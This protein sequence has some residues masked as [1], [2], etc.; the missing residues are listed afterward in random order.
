[1]R[2]HKS[3]CSGPEL[4]RIKRGRGFSYLDE[5]GDAV[6]DAETLLR[7]RE[8][9]SA[10]LCGF[11]TRS[12]RLGSDGYAAADSGVGLATLRKEHLTFK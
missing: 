7:I 8:L 3:D 5:R 12:F 9:A 2:I 6:T 1:M 11:S 10:R 4:R